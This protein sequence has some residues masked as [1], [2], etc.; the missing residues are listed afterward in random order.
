[1]KP[2]ALLSLFAAALLGACTASAPAIPAPVATAPTPADWRARVTAAKA[3]ADSAQRSAALLAL[4]REALPGRTVEL[5]GTKDPDQIDRADYQPAPIVNFDPLLNQ[6]TSAER[7]S[8]GPTRSLKNN[9]GYYFSAD[10]VPY[11]VI[12]PA[13]V[14][15]RSPLFTELAAEHELFHAENHVGDSRPL[16]DRE[17]ETW[18]TMFTR[19]F[20][21]VHR[22]RQQWAP[23]LSYYETASPEERKAAIE[24]LSAYHR[25]AS[26]DLSAA[27]NEWMAR[28]KSESQRSALIRDLEQVIGAAPAVASNQANNP[29]ADPEWKK[30]VTEA[31]ALG[32]AEKSAAMLALLREALPAHDVRLSGEVHHP[33][34]VVNFDATMTDRTGR[35]FV[36]EGQPYVVIGPRA[37]DERG[38]VFTRMLV[39]HELFHATHHVGDTRPAAERELETWTH[40]FVTYFREVIPFKQRWAPLVTHYEE[41]GGDERRAALEKLVAYYRA[42]PPEVRTAFDEWLERRRKDSATASSALVADLDQSLRAQSTT[43]STHSGS[44][45]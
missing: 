35:Y 26:A 27:M 13:A 40:V 6:K 5:S 24:R 29:A 10:G 7:K 31:K 14:D 30:R 8:G 32:D 34:P 16:A 42:A 39:E 41:A 11:V 25:T 22:F 43:G 23:M 36:S 38:V 3:S 19:Y 4:I 18:T 28:R 44:G 12:G 17:L 45:R 33:A 37:L 1:M 2:L 9:F 15:A 21:D 20:D